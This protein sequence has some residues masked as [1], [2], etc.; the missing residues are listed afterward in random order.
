MSIP[1]DELNSRLTFLL[2]VFGWHH[3]YLNDHKTLDRENVSY[4]ELPVISKMH[5]PDVT[6]NYLQIKKDVTVIV[7]TE[8]E[9]MLDTQ[10]LTD[11]IIKK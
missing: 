10:E 6:K 8:I 4:K 9:R 1:P 5:P 2:P 11:L 7:H 3:S